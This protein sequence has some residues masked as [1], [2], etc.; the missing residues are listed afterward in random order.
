MEGHSGL[1]MRIPISTV[2]VD[3]FDVAS[4]IEFK[5]IF[6]IQKPST[7]FIPHAPWFLPSKKGAFIQLGKGAGSR[8]PAVARIHNLIYTYFIGCDLPRDGWPSGRNK[9]ASGRHVARGLHFI[10]I[11][12]TNGLLQETEEWIYRVKDE[13]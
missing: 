9:S 2:N 8:P 3:A 6:L 1:L 11:L 10:E 5:T 4:H 13:W 7:L 12:K